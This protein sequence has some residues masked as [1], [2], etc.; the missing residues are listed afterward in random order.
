MTLAR[1]QKLRIAIALLTAVIW[2][3][4]PLTTFL[5]T[6]SV[7]LPL[8]FSAVFLLLGGVW[9]GLERLEKRMYRG[10]DVPPRNLP[11]KS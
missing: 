2:A 3:M 8:S 4:I 5:Q 9:L 7:I 1:I 10:E 6:K 11:K